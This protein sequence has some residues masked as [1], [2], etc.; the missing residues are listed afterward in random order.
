MSAC[1]SAWTMSA[2]SRLDGAH[3][4]MRNER[5]YNSSLGPTRVGAIQTPVTA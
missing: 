1:T 5:G 2:C 4:T 3:Y